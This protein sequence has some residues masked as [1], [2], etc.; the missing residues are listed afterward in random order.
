MTLV[1]EVREGDLNIRAGIVIRY[2][3]YVLMQHPTPSVKWP[4]PL[5]EI[6]KGHLREGESPKD[7]AIRECFEES[8]IK[9]EPWKLEQ[10]RLPIAMRLYT[11]F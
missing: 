9:F 8:N 4:S 6:Q 3:N 5:W 11:F 2:K 1:R 10:P 7:G